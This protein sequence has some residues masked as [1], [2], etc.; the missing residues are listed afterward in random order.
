MAKARETTS[1]TSL[2]KS[3]LAA[4]RAKASRAALR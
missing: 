2:L 4:T 3:A 1:R